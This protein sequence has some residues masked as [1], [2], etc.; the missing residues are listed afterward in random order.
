MTT[1][2]LSSSSSTT[3]TTPSSSS[4]SSSSSSSSSQNHHQCHDQQQQHQQ[5][6][7]QEPRDHYSKKTMDSIYATLLEEEEEEDYDIDNDHDDH[8]APDN[9]DNCNN[10]NGESKNGNLIDD[11]VSFMMTEPS[12]SPSTSEGGRGGRDYSSNFI[13]NTKIVYHKIT[14]PLSSSTCSSSCYSNTIVNNNDSTAVTVYCTM[15][16]LHTCPV[17]LKTLQIDINQ[18]LQVLPYSVHYL[19]CNT[20]IYVNTTYQYTPTIQIPLTMNDNDNDS[21]SKN[22]NIPPPPPPPPHY[23]HQHNQ[24]LMQQQPPPP[25]TP[26]VLGH[27][28]THHDS[29]WLIHW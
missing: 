18:C 8:L 19:I 29:G 13:D 7:Q 2:S 27:L 25:Q 24:Q 15:D 10:R 20:N 5:E 3:T 14:L 1:E 9:T 11:T 12:T 22:S 6:Q 17:I 16:V 4:I 26:Y 21:D 28:T 23:Y